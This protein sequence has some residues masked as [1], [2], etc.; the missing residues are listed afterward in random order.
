MKLG[1][2]KSNGSVVAAIFEDTTHARPIPDY[3]MFD[4]VE[5]LG[6]EGGDLKTLASRLATAHVVETTPLI[7]ISP[8]E[9]WGAGC[10]YEISSSFRDAEHGTREGFY[11]AVFEGGRPELFF[12]G[13]AR[14][15]VGPGQ[16]IG[17]REDS[18]FTAPEPELAVLIGAKGQILGY[19]VSNDVS[20]WD[21]E[22][23]NPLYLPQSKTFT[24]CAAIGPYF[25]TP[26]ELGDV[27]NLEMT[28]TI[29][30]G[31]VT[32]FEGSTNTSK[33]GRKIE[34]LI[35]YLLRSNQVPS[36]TVLQTGTGIIVTQESALAAGDIVSI[37]VPQIGTLSNPAAIV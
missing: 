8:R 32:T 37:T 14:I 20:A 36:G 13:T 31:D 24:G 9:V 18:T 17:I 34:D 29:K 35:G 28:C 11:R 19:T 1:Q 6:V 2:I 30:R 22:K 21:I 33:L 3:S 4:L 7:P 15:A 12:K 5:R 23:E 26:D 25:V 10:T 16:P 27:Y